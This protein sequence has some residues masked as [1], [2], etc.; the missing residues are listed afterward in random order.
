MKLDPHKDTNLDIY[1]YIYINRERYISI[2]LYMY[3]RGGDV[4]AAQAKQEDYMTATPPVPPPVPH[5]PLTTPPTRVIR[6]S[7]SVAMVAHVLAT[8]SLMY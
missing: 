7:S 1:I 3:M 6:N 2:Y 8:S 5:Q 4:T